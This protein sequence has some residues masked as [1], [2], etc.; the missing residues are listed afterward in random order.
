MANVLFKRG[1]QANLPKSAEDGVFYL[2]TDTNRLYVGQQTNMRLLNQN[3]SIVANLKELT[4]ESDN[5]TAAQKLA[6][7]EDFYYITANNILAVWKATQDGGYEWV[8]INPD[9][10]VSSLT[11]SSSVAN[12]VGTMQL[13]VA[14]QNGKTTATAHFAIAATG[15][16]TI[17]TT[18]SSGLVI[19]AKEY[20]YALS[21]DFSNETA[22]TGQYE[23]AN[24][25]LTD[26][27]NSTTSVVSLSAG[28]NI[29]FESNGTDVIKINAKNTTIGG[30]TLG[31]TGNGAISVEVADDEGYSEV[32]VLDNIGIV[33]NDGT[34]YVPLSSTSGKTQGAIY[35]KAEIDSMLAGLD[36]MTYKGVINESTSL[37]TTQVKNG[38][39]YIVS[40]SGTLSWLNTSNY[41]IMHGQIPAD[42]VRVGDMFIA[43][44]TEQNGVITGNV[45]WTYVPSGNEEFGQFI[46]SAE[47]DA[48]NNTL[49]LA[50][51]AGHNV[52]GLQLAAST[53]IVVNSST[54]G[55]HTVDLITTISHAEYTTTSTTSVTTGSESFSAISGITI[56]NGHITGYNVETFTPVK[57][58]FGDTPADTANQVN[59]YI[60]VTTNT[61]AVIATNLELDGESEVKSS[62]LINLTS[63]TLKF[64]TNNNNSAL[65]LD[66]EW[67]T[68]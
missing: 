7:V 47:S 44:G 20:N 42:G 48:S 46:Y 29:H 55:S 30:V 49:T 52:F 66:F 15:G 54:A 21:R 31:L 59:S 9:T 5:W 51:D 58:I 41:T 67:G 25:Y 13:D 68:F 22:T 3:I 26:S 60:N 32:G 37:P 11:Y 63:N 45:Q 4:D 8:Q 2:T 16:A 50:N 10:Y 27:S 40:E 56:N 24:I 39:V 34:H 57:Y 19:N 43:V 64:S 53:G 12:N 65:Q 14:D 35:S 61:E 17:S 28:S 6:H 33:L 62:S 36:G 23:K 1:L 38:D 18:G